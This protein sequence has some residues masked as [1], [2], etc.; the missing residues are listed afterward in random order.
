MPAGTLQ[1]LCLRISLSGIYETR[2]L[3]KSIIN[4]Y[5]AGKNRKDESFTHNMSE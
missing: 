2:L 5:A 1:E 3:L 4:S